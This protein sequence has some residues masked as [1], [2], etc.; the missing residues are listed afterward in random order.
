VPTALVYA[1]DDEFFEPAWER[2]VSR[3]LLRVDPEI[4]G[5]HFPMVEDP[6]GLA[7]L[8]DDLTRSRSFSAAD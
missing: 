6:D 7:D 3:E 2:H 8:L 5:G 4:A 1:A